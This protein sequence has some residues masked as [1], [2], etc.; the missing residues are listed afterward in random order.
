MKTPTSIVHGDTASLTSEERNLE[1]RDI[2]LT[3]LRRWKTAQINPQAAHN[4]L[5][6]NRIQSVHAS[7]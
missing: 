3:A 7:R 5:D 1:I 2:L 4:E 6:I